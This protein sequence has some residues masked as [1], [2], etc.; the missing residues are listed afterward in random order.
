MDAALSQVGKPYQW[1]ASGPNSYDCSGLSM[2]AWRQAG[3]NIPRTSREQWVG[4]SNFTNRSQLRP[5][6]LVFFSRTGRPED[7][8]HL[9]MYIGGGDVVEAPFTG[10][11]VRINST[12]LNRSDLIG[13]GRVP[14]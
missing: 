3:V 6:D 12:A 8:H 2:W 5:G 13:F 11:N 14:H 9:A 10:A 1:G 7:I 4:T